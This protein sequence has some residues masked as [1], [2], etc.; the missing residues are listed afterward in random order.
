MYDPHDLTPPDGDFTTRLRAVR[1]ASPRLDRD[2]LMYLA[3][4][5]STITGRKT[6]RLWPLA[7]AA[8]WAACA[9]LV[10]LAFTRP[11]VVVTEVK[12][13]E[14]IVETPVPAPTTDVPAQATDTPSPQVQASRPAVGESLES[15]FDLA[16]LDDLHQPLTVLAS[17]PELFERLTLPATVAATEASNIA[18][19]PRV[20]PTYGKLRREWLDGNHDWETPPRAWTWF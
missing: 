16:F 14:R 12:I 1:P 11:P 2:R 6:N 8:S 13:V 7:T 19:E 10:A 17:R 5:R 4:Q 9:G 3:G 20:P 15:P 18:V